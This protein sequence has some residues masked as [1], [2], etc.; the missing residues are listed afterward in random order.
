MLR[1][2]LYLDTDTLSNY[3]STLEGYTEVEVDETLTEHRSGGAELSMKVAKVAGDVENV[4][5]KKRRLAVT[6]EARFQRLYEILDNQ[7]ETGIPYLVGLTADVW[8]QQQRGSIVE[9]QARLRLPKIVQL[10]QGVETLSPFLDLLRLIGQDPLADTEEEKMFQGMR[11]I[12]ESLGEKPLPLLF[13]PVAASGYQ[14]F[15]NLAR[16]HLRCSPSELEGEA[17]IFG[18][19]MRIIEKGKRET[20]FSLLPDLEAFQPTNR[21][22][23]RRLEQNDQFVESI[24]GPAAIAEV[25]AVYR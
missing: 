22:Q 7:N 16:E 4:A 5:S 18:K 3:L 20:V 2:F 10:L 24:K 21:K 1:N 12:G 17:T 19:I 25:I 11:G 23:R 13:H 9:I 15:A 6:D 8:R 14:L